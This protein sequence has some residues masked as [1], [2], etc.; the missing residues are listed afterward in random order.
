[1][2]QH[3][4]PRNLATIA[5]LF[6]LVAALDRRRVLACALMAPAALLHPMMALYGASLVSLFLWR[7]LPLHYLGFV[8]L[9]PFAWFL[10]PP[11]SA[12][13]RQAAEAYLF[14]TK[15]AWYEW[16]GIVG[17]LAGLLA[18]RFWAKS[19]QLPLIVSSA[20][21]LVQFGVFYTLAAVTIS[22]IPR[23][24]ELIRLQP[25]RNLQPIYLFLFLFVGGIVGQTFRRQWALVAS[26]LFLGL[27]GGMFYAQR[28]EF[29]ASPHI[30]LPGR[31]PDNAWLQAF[32]WIRRSTPV[33]AYFVTDPRYMERPGEDFHSFRA[34]AE[35]GMLADDI[36]DRAV[37]TVDFRV[38]E[39]WL[40]RSEAQRN[41]RNF[42][43]ADL[44]GLKQ[45]FGVDWVLFERGAPPDSGALPC[46]YQNDQIRV[47][48]IE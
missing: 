43:R 9:L 18:C 1:M 27:C 44:L 14:V 3:L 40:T 10:L 33:R 6:A 4:H 34:L 23:F 15:W 22:S 8:L 35:R 7:T 45:R 13:W 29:P 41:W 21:K 37:A 5:M 32:D 24:E 25:M 2:D 39:A 11:A 28:Q 47:C 19:R 38:A 46:P 42:S 48:R 16:V 20:W 36:K 30:E 31:V 17:P 12:A 26:V